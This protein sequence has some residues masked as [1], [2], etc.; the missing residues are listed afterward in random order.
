MCFLLENKCLIYLLRG[1]SFEGFAFFISLLFIRVN[2]LKIYFQAE[3]T[4]IY[5]LLQYIVLIFE[6]IKHISSMKGHWEKFIQFFIATFLD[7]LH[8]ALFPRGI[9]FFFGIIIT[10]TLKM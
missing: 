8:L 3:D 10:H 4:L 2:K 7:Y 9:F 5:C 6:L 1:Y